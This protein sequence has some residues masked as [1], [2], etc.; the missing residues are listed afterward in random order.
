MSLT[1]TLFLF[2]L[3]LAVHF[4]STNIT[5]D[6]WPFTARDPFLAFLGTTSC[7]AQAHV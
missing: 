7:V 1:H 2:S 4:I 3:A 6:D 5:A